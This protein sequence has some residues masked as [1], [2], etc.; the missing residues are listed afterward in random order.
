MTTISFKPSDDFFRVYLNTSFRDAGSTRANPQWTIK[1]YQDKYKFYKRCIMVVE[2]V[3]WKN[4]TI[5]ILFL[6]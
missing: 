4:Q 2:R 1:N 5:K 6:L 3:D